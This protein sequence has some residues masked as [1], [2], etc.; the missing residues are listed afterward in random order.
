M[1]EIASGCAA[2]QKKRTEES[3]QLVVWNQAGGGLIITTAWR[4]EHPVESPE[5]TDESRNMTGN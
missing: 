1:I 3:E 5:K 2:A 4:M